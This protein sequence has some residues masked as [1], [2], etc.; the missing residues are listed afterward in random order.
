MNP[1]TATDESVL[2]GREH[3][4]PCLFYLSNSPM[5]VYAVVL[6]ISHILANSVRLNA[7]FLYCG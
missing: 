2:Y 4:T 6:L 5:Y 3:N 7:P 1:F